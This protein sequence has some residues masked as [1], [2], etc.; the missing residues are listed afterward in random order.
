MKYKCKVCGKEVSISRYEQTIPTRCPDCDLVIA[1]GEYE[2]NIK[3]GLTLFSPVAMDG[4]LGHIVMF[5][6]IKRHYKAA[7]PDEKIKMLHVNDIKDLQRK[8]DFQRATKIFWADTC[9]APPIKSDKII[10]YRFS[11]ELKA[12]GKMDIYPKWSK[13]EP[14]EGLTLDAPFFVLHGRNIDRNPSKNM[15]T[16]E[17]TAILAAIAEHK[18]ILDAR[19]NVK[20][21]VF[22]VGNDEAL[23][24]ELP[25]FVTDLRSKLSL[26]QIAYLC[27]HEKCIAT[28]GKDS[29]IQHLAAAAGGRVLGYGYK[30]LN[31][32]IPNSDKAQGFVQ[33]QKFYAELLKLV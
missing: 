3:N 17:Y 28:V 13:K 19:S 22:Q 6:A 27:G 8:R 26:N 23:V 4:N 31:D 7:N 12:L 11:K 14:I 1:T 5:E 15:S 16:A 30:S 33:F 9:T 2:Q 32:W 20:T 21:Q 29:G 24:D 25:E 18:S 10:R